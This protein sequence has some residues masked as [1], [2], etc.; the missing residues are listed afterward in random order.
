MFFLT[1]FLA[2]EICPAYLSIKKYCVWH[3][4]KDSGHLGYN[5]VGHGSRSLFQI[6]NNKLCIVNEQFSYFII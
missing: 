2:V 4:M 1:I 5:P 6:F 3:L